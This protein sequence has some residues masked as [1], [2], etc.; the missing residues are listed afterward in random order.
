MDFPLF[1]KNAS[2]MQKRIYLTLFMFVIVLLFTIIG[3]YIPVNREYANSIYNNLNQTVSSY[4]TNLGLATASIFL[5]NFRI[6]LVMFVPLA[7]LI[8]GLATILNTGV[9]LGAIATVRGYP[10]ILEIINL[11]ASPVTWIE[12]SAYAI[13]LAEG[14]WLLRRILQQK[15]GE[16]K[17]AVILIGVCGIILILSALLES[18]LIINGY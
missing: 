5:N 2:S 13:A 12:F 3:S 16:L 9:A 15:Y 4:G 6:C 7:G 18:W 14:V 10:V 1:W 11:L 17:N 8:V